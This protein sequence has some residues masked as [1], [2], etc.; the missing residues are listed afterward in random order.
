MTN[1]SFLFFLDLQS[2]RGRRNQIGWDKRMEEKVD[3]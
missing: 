2:E 1:E 3:R